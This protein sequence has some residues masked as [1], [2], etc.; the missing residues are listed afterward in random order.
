MKGLYRD[1]GKRI[2]SIAK[3]SFIIG[4]IISAIWG[5]GL[6]AKGIGI[7]ARGIGIGYY[8]FF[9]DLFII[10]FRIVAVIVGILSFYISSCWMCGFGELIERTTEIAKKYK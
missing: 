5:W 4:V 8:S 6:D 3:I 7:I 9:Y 10:S 1:I 2:K